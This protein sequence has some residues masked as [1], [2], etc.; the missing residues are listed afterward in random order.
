MHMH[1]ALTRPITFRPSPQDHVFQALEDLLP[2][3]D[4]SLRLSNSD[5]PHLREIIR[6]VSYQQYRGLL[7]SLVRGAGAVGGTLALGLEL[8]RE[9]RLLARGQHPLES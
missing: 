8:H 1:P 9:A 7:S 6:S 2:Y 3:E 5:L 4:F